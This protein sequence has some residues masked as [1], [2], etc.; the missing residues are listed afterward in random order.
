MDL[1]PL[2][3]RFPVDVELSIRVRFFRAVELTVQAIRPGPGNQ[4]NSLINPVR[5]D[6]V[7]AIRC[8]EK[9]RE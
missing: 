1:I 7:E 3:K 6:L 4:P 9:E 2:G 5:I 8:C